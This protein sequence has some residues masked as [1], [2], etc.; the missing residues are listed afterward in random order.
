MVKLTLYK[1]DCLEVM[2]DLPD[3][4]IDLI[5]CDPPY[6]LSYNNEDLASH[7]EAIFGGKQERMKPNGIKQMKKKRQWL[8][9]RTS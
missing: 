2:K 4:S 5:A 9:L 3:K 8:C 6:G 1:G 7:R